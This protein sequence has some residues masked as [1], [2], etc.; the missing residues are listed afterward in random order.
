MLSINVLLPGW[1]GSSIVGNVVLPAAVSREQCF[2]TGGL[3]VTD[4]LYRPWT[5]PVILK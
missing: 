4:L 2:F 1:C 3:Q 5:L